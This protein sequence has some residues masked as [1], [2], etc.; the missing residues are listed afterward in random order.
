MLTCWTDGMTDGVRH[1]RDVVQRPRRPSR[2]PWHRRLSSSPRLRCR[3]HR[4]PATDGAETTTAEGDRG[5]IRDAVEQ[6]ADG[7]GGEWGW[8]RRRGRRGRRGQ[9]AAGGTHHQSVRRLVTG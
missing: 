8:R 6:Q 3:L 5:A 1:C 4:P 2:R 7:I 9:P